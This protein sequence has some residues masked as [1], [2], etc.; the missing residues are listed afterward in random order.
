ML[1]LP[2]GFFPWGLPTKTFLFPACYFLYPSNTNNIRRWVQIVKRSCFVISSYC[3]DYW[4]FI[5]NYIVTFGS[6][7]GVREWGVTKYAYQW[8]YCLLLE[9]DY[10]HVWLLHF[11]IP[12]HVKEYSHKLCFNGWFFCQFKDG[13][14]KCERKRCLRSSC[15]PVVSSFTSSRRR[16]ISQSTVTTDEC[17][18]QCRRNRRHHRPYN[19]WAAS[20]Y[21]ECISDI[22]HNAL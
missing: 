3:A 18:S 13:S 21:W 22:N 12:R 4:H 15:T 1:E 16:N 20:A 8:V 17:C 9:T 10:V 11:L 19:S 2:S 5:S 14:I 6:K 7:K